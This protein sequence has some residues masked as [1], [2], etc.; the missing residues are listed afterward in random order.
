[1]PKKKPFKYHPF[2]DTALDLFI[3]F[4][5]FNAFAAF[6]GLG[7][8]TI[9]LVFATLVMIDYWWSTRTF[10]QLPK[11]YLADFYLITLV[12]FVFFVWPGQIANPVIFLRLTAA[13]FFL[14]ALFAFTAIF[15]HEERQDEDELRFYATTEFFLSAYYLLIS[16]VGFKLGWPLVAALFIPYVGWYT[17]EIKNGYIPTKFVEVE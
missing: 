3:G 1:M 5:L 4:A 14:D 7:F 16:F 6:N 2:L 8:E 13:F 17:Y 12:M 9:L 11:H 10:H 15:T